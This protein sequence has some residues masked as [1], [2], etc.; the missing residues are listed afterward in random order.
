M[1]NTTKWSS[2]SWGEVAS[3]LLFKF[4]ERKKISVHEMWHSLQP[5][6]CIVWQW[7][8]YPIRKTCK[9]WIMTLSSSM[10]MYSVMRDIHDTR[11][12]PMERGWVAL[13]L[14]ATCKYSNSLTLEQ[15]A[16][17]N[18]LPFFFDMHCSN[19]MSIST[20]IRNIY[21]FLGGMNNYP[22]PPPPPPR[23]AATANMFD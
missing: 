3:T 4:P 6:H 19:V 23:T 16:F 10:A 1:S 17:E 15:W 9:K 7:R 8:I 2:R 22:L 20:F 14:Y 13:Y 11:R 12:V 5:H 18:G 21:N